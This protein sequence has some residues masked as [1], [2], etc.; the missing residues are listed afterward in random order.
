[1]RYF[2]FIALI[3]IVSPR[4]TF[5]QPD[6]IMVWNKWCA[7]AD[8]PLLFPT[9]NNIIQIVSKG[10][11][12]AD[13]VVKSLDNALKIGNPEYK[14]DTISFMAMP[15]P[16]YG[17][18]MRLT[19]SQKNNKKVLK[20]VNFG[21]EEAPVPTAMLGNI[22]GD[23]PARKQ[24]VVQSH[25]RVG[26]ANSLYSYPYRVKSYTF[27]ARVGGKDITIP[28]KGSQVTNEITNL[29]SIAAEGTF[30]EFTEIKAA[31]YECEPRSLPDLKLWIK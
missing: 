27:K 3:L 24:L 8:T 28:V 21:A 26:F 18:R 30:V 20:T 1:M 22:V 13:L 15:Y 10:I 5:A 25:L 17:K 11:K 29:M 9:G 14:G 2:L 6:S 16:K 12:P 23:H 31:C 4:N 7:K 19:I